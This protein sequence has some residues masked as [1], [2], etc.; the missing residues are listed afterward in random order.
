MTEFNKSI[1]Y[2]IDQK[3]K[4]INPDA[5]WICVGAPKQED[6]LL[7]ITPSKETQLIAC[8]G[9]VIDDLAY[10]YKHPP[11]LISSLGLEWLFRLLT[12][13]RRTWKR[14]LISYPL[15]LLIAFTEFLKR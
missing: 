13:F 10:P 9:A 15:F 3:I 2:D 14:V 1:L 6:L 5:V 4:E 12:G 8:V 11:R 7:R